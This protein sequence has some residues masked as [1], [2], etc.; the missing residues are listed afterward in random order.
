MSNFRV[1]EEVVCVSKTISH[2]TKVGHTYTVTAKC[3][4]GCGEKLI[5]TEIGLQSSYQ[6]T[7]CSSCGTFYEGVQWYKEDRFRRIVRNSVYEE[8]LDKFPLEEE[9]LDGE[10]KVIEPLKLNK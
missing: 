5:Q 6:R 1:G 2:G 7:K 8:L 3:V 9:K 10:E 4:C